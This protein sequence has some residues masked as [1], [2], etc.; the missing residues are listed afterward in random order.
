MDYQEF[1]C[2]V[3]E[4][5]NK[6]L[7][8]G[9]KASIYTAVKNNGSIKKGVLIETPDDNT[10]PA[11]YLDEFFERFQKGEDIKQLAQEVLVFYENIR[12]KGTWNCDSFQNYEKIR[13][14]VLFRLI[15]TEKNEGILK[16]IPH[17]QVLDLSV[18]FYILLESGESENATVQIRNE[19]LKL[20]GIQKEA[21]YHSAVE[22]ASK[23]LPAEF[24]TMRH[25]VEEMLECE[26]TQEE[27]LLDSRDDNVQDVMYIL[28]NSIRSYGAACMVYPHV[29]E[30]IGGMLKENFFVLPSS[31]HEIIIV[32]ESKGI[33]EEEM[34]EMVNEINEAQVAPEEVLSNHAYFYQREGGKL[35]M[36]R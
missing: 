12:I 14:K 30:M 10:A 35:M 13:D 9:V 15:N 32:P 1:L 8:G 28:T 27:N 11:M 31:V 36:K 6:R 34:S 23:L 2:A 20:W 18:V 21:L 26:F 29:L 19:H 17:I 7:E 5:L 3:K 4:E 24:F 16:Y 33:D 25:A 22:N